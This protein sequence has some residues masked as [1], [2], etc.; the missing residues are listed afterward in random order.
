[1]REAA[2]V[3]SPCEQWRLALLFLTVDAIASRRNGLQPLEANCIAAMG[4]TAERAA[5]NAVKCNLDQA[6]PVPIHD[7]LSDH[8][9]FEGVIRRGLR[10]IPRYGVSPIADRGLGLLNGLL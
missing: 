9:T 10:G 6:Q 3:L 1:M 8:R 4:A 5:A 7:Q 2:Q